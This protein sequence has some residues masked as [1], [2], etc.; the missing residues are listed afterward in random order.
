[1]QPIVERRREQRLKIIAWIAAMGAVMFVAGGA[2]FV[3]GVHIEF[4]HGFA[5]TYGANPYS[6]PVSNGSNYPTG[7]FLGGLGLLA[8]VVGLGLLVGSLVCWVVV[9]RPQFRLRSCFL[10]CLI[11]AVLFACQPYAA[12]L[13]RYYGV[14]VTTNAITIERSQDF[15]SGSPYRI[16]MSF[17]LNPRWLVLVLI[18]TF[19]GIFLIS[20]VYR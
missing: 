14:R 6:P 16:E 8:A 11:F 5:T 1:M 4:E 12:R 13:A 9:R 20:R 7:M 2:A 17:P 18:P 3:A 19:S 15:R 10:V